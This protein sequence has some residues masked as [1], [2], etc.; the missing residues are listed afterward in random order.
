MDEMEAHC[1]C[2]VRKDV[3]VQEFQRKLGA[4]LIPQIVNYHV[5]E[6]LSATY[7]LNDKYS[8]HINVFLVSN[9]LK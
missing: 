8:I 6:T 5:E 9:K 3:E 1:C 4:F 7:V 2:I